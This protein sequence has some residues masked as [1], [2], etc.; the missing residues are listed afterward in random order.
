MEETTKFED[1]TIQSNF[2]FKHVM[3]NKN[4]CQYFISNVMQCEV[5]DLEYIETEKELE[6]YFDSK[7]VRLDVILVDKNNNRYNLE[8][9]V[10]NVLGKETKLPLLPKRARYY[11]SVMDMDMLQKGQS[12]DQ[13]SPLVLVFVCA[14]DLFNEGRYVYTFKSR[15]LENLDLELGNDVTTMFLNANG[16]AGAVTPQMVNFLEYVRTQ[17]PNDAYT[18]ELEAEV[19][20]LKQ[21]K[22]VRRK[23]MVLQAE[24]RDTQIIAFEAGEAQGHAA[25]LA[26]GE[27]NKFVA[28][29][30]RKMK[31]KN[32]TC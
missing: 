14:F 17:V 9:Q 27:V 26:E 29:V 23:Y 13:L 28:M 11:Q 3:G 2:M 7:C 19:A 1:L 16:V 32:T 5:V 20:R 31:R 4:L 22:E 15:C 6:P 18:H 10:R 30:E 8:M 25:G 21:D 24:L 12:Y